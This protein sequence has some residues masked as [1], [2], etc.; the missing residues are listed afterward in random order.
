[1]AKEGIFSEIKR[2]QKVFRVV[3]DREDQ[4]VGS[5]LYIANKD[6]FPN[7]VHS[8]ATLRFDYLIFGITIGLTLG[9]I[10]ILVLW[11]DAQ[12]FS[13]ALTFV[14]ICGFSGHLMDRIRIRRLKTGRAWLGIWELLI[15]TTIPCLMYLA[16]RIAMSMVEP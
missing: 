4:P 3:V 11:P 13:V 5:K 9:A 1:M 8:S 16:A 7:R 15:L 12:S 14:A 10:A 2:Q 6:R